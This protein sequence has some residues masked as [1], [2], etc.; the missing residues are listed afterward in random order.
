[1]YYVQDLIHPNWNVVVK[2]KPR[3]VY[4]VDEGEGHDN[5]EAD[6][7]HE[8]EPFNVNIIGDIDIDSVNDDIDCARTNIPATEALK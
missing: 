8:H 2:T 1:V 5:E 3:N 4:D 6:S 7:F